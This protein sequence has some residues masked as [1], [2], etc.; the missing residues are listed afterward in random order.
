M[1]SALVVFLWNFVTKKWSFVHDNARGLSQ[2]CPYPPGAPDVRW[3]FLFM[4]RSG[5]SA[6]ERRPVLRKGPLCDYPPRRWHAFILYTL[7]PALLLYANQQLGLARQVTTIPQLLAMPE[8][9]QYALRAA[10]YGHRELIEAFVHANPQRF[11]DEDLAL[12]ES[13]KHFVQGQFYVFRHLKLYTV[14]LEASDTPKAYGVLALHDDFPDLFPH[15]PLLIDTVLL[16][17]KNQITYDGQ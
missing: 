16:P 9:E 1:V 15:V 3:C 8:E 5:K 17:F 7:Y 14:F 12:V 6:C 2:A 11:S 4:P 10:F 13:W